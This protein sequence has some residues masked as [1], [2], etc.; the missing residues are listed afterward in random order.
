MPLQ[1]VLKWYGEDFI[2][3]ARAVS[4]QSFKLHLTSKFG[5]NIS[6][7][8]ACNW[9]W[10]IA[11]IEPSPF[12]PKGYELPHDENNRNDSAGGRTDGR[13]YAG[14]DKERYLL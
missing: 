6:V 14:S 12:G 9:N 8:F 1:L 11:G 5:K 13:T 4:L 3:Y 7:L 2:V 10:E